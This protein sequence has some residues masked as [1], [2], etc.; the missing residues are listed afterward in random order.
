MARLTRLSEPDKVVGEWERVKDEV[1][2]DVRR[3]RELGGDDATS[4]K[5]DLNGEGNMKRLTELL[6]RMR[7]AFMNSCGGGE[8]SGD[9]AHRDASATRAASAQRSFITKQLELPFT[10]EENKWLTRQLDRYKVVSLCPWCHDFVAMKFH[11]WSICKN[12]EVPHRSK[13]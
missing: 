7:D 8:K 13:V 12:Y 1:L 11:T 4:D 6:I 3:L 2:S 5:F 10:V 9:R